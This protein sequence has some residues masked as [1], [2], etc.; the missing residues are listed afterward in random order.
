M[1]ALRRPIARLASRTSLPVSRHTLLLAARSVTTGA[2]SLTPESRSV[3]EQ[4]LAAE[5]AATNT[6]KTKNNHYLLQ[7]GGLVNHDIFWGDMDTFGHVNN[8]MYLKWFETGKY[9]FFFS[10][11]G[12]KEKE[13]DNYE[14]QNETK[15]KKKKS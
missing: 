9:G 12:Y 15:P 7:Y 13:G 10:F 11:K 4:V 2:Y 14:Q 8:V 6:D 5:D 3:L 1:Y